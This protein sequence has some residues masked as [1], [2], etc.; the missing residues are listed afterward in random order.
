MVSL[1]LRRLSPMRGS[2]LGGCAR[3]ASV[4]GGRL[5]LSP[6]LGRELGVDPVD[7]AGVMVLAPQRRKRIPAG[8]RVTAVATGRRGTAVATGR[9]GFTKT[10]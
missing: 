1:K 4:G 10:R 5:E 9:P 8:L 2:A 7:P 6:L 3:I